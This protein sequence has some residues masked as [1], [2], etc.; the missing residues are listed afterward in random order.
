MLK[1]AVVI[2]T[3]A[4]SG[5][6]EAAAREF[7]KQGANVVLAARRLDR[8][9]A[10]AKEL[11]VYGIKAVPIQADLSKRSDMETAVAQTI[12]MFGK[13]D[14]LFNNAGFGRLDFLD[15]LDAEKDIVPQI[16][17]N[18]LGVI[19]M[20]QVVLPYMMKAHAGHIINMSSIAGWVATPT[21]SVYAASKFAIRGFSESLRREVAPW[22]ISVS[23]IYPYSVVTEFGE[24]AGINR[25]TKSMFSGKMVLTADYVAKQVVRTVTY[26]KSDIIL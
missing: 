1:G 4:S 5:I 21:Y 8:L 12:G 6:G 22:G 11:E 9:D 13:I 7:A 3:G 2:V 15:K 18:L 16:T 14:I 25:K 23:T 19:Q 24:H 20:T 10:L 26:P 17:V